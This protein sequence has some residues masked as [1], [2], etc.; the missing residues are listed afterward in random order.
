MLQFQEQGVGVFLLLRGQGWMQLPD[1]VFHAEKFVGD[2]TLGMGFDGIQYF[3][4]GSHE[5]TL[6]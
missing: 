6:C 2:G 1:F 4:N 5:W 3:S